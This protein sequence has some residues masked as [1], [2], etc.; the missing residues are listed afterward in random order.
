MLLLLLTDFC[1][2]G[3]RHC[4]SFS[5]RS[6]NHEQ[7]A[8]TDNLFRYMGK[9]GAQA[10]LS[11]VKLF[12]YFMNSWVISRG[13]AHLNLRLL[14]HSAHQEGMQH[15]HSQECTSLKIYYFINGSLLISWSMFARTLCYKLQ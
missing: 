12:E 15:C 1:Q 5:C 7:T 2:F 4:L 11:I 3:K 9:K 14:C 13:N 10:E 6:V 8:P